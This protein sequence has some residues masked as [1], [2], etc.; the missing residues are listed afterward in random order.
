MSAW[1]LPTTIRVDGRELKIR[2]DFRAVLD[3]ISALND[4]ELFMQEKLAACLAIMVPEYATVQ[5]T[6]GAIREIFKFINLGQEERQ[7]AN[8]PKLVDWDRDVQLIA[9]AVDKALGFSCRRAPYLH[10]WEFIGAYN[11]IGRGPF[12]EVVSI[13][14]KRA[15]GKKLEP[16]EQDYVRDNPELFSQ[17]KELTAEEEAFFQA[18]GV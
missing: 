2:S 16:W 17:H 10:W 5:D 15:K 6:N 8:S 3:A 11:N 13:R 1:S 14:S 12:A 18:L 4:P 9:P 7:A